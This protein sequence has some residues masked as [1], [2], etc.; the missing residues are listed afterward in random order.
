LKNSKLLTRSRC[1][2]KRPNWFAIDAAFSASSLTFDYQI[3]EH[4]LKTRDTSQLNRFFVITYADLKKYKYYYWFAFPA[5]VAKPAWEIGDEG[6]T[7]A[8]DTLDKEGVCPSLLVWNSFD[9]ASLARLNLFPT[10]RVYLSL[11]PRP[12]RR[13]WLGN[14]TCRRVRELLCLS[15][16]FQGKYPI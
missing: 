9:D 8:V 16:S 14:C 15:A 4:T 6:W 2:I 12:E 1:S 7:N 13:S 11:F 10:S 3:W 5:F